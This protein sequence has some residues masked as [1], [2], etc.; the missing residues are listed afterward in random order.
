MGRPPKPTLLHKLHGTTRPERHAV[1]ER[2]PKPTG[3]LGADA[4]P[5]H[6]SAA[7]REVWKEVVEAAP[8]GLLARI[9]GG[10][11]EAYV[12]ALE[13][14]R[15]AVAAQNALDRGKALP[16]LHRGDKGVIT[17]SPYIRII[18]KAATVLLR[19]AGECG[20]TPASRPRLVA[21]PDPG[22]DG[23]APSPWDA[24]SVIP[25]GRE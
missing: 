9:D 1:R 14:H 22:A 5:A 4:P 23:G 25:G 20:F 15:R 17:M 11:I 12:I 3:K 21:N 18:D 19:A 16:F 2:E 8:A 10:A 24:F 6:L 13:A 7:Q